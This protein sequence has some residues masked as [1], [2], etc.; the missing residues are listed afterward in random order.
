MPRVHP[1][2]LPYLWL[3]NCSV[4]LK[5]GVVGV[6][7]K[8]S[9]QHRDRS[10]LFSALQLQRQ[11]GLKRYETAWMMLHKLRRAMVA[12]ERSPLSGLIEVD[13]AYIGGTD[14]GRRGGRDAFGAATI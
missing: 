14:S 6:Q 12:P 9:L 7:G 2:S 4:H 10:R 11:L 1:E 13:D 5:D 3:G 8:G